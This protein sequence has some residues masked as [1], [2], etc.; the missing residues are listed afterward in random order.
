MSEQRLPAGR[1]ACTL[2]VGPYEEL[3]DV[4]GRF[5]GQWLPPKRRAPSR[6]RQL[7]NLPQQ[8]DGRTQARAAHRAVPPARLNARDRATL[9][10]E[11]ANPSRAVG[12]R[13][14]ARR[15]VVEAGRTDA[16]RL[17]R[18][19]GAQGRAIARTC[20]AGRSAP[21]AHVWRR[22]QPSRLGDDAICTEF[23]L[24]GG[25]SAA[26]AAGPR[27]M[28]KPCSL[29]GLEAGLEAYPARSLLNASWTMRAPTNAE[30]TSFHPVAPT[31]AAHRLTARRPRA[32]SANRRGADASTGLDRRSARLGGTA[33]GLLEGLARSRLSTRL[34]AVSVVANP[35]AAAQVTL[36]REPH[37]ASSPRSQPDS[38]WQA[39]A[40]RRR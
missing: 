20:R 16:R 30:T 8:P 9:A 5:M 23:R 28:P 24:E 37:F 22:G 3:G 26:A 32:R 29:A 10:P 2:N 12:N 27:I 39:A 17:R 35:I 40:R 33:A 6:R 36:P 15:A 18:E 19:Q 38:A 31:R 34:L 21:C 11:S 7:R 13:R 25:S 4:W 1:Y 14:P